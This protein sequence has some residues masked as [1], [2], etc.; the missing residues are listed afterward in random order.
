MEKK[1]YLYM[2]N[3]TYGEVVGTYKLNILE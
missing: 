1:K 3:E 2:K